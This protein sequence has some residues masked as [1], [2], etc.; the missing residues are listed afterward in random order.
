MN[1]TVALIG[2]G[3]MGVFFA[4]RL[5][6]HENFFVIADGERKTRLETKGVTVNDV[7]YKFPV[8]TPD[9]TGTIADLI[10][11]S[12]KRY[13]LEQS[14]IDIKNFVGEN[15]VILCVMNGI[16]SEDIV[17]KAYGKNRVLRSY[18]RISIVMTNGI[19]N[20][21][22]NGGQVHFG[23]DNN[24]V[25][26]DNVKKVQAIFDESGIPYITDEDMV[27]S[28]WFKFMCN[29]GEN[30][31]CAC[32][33]IPFGAFRTS[34]EANV[35]RIGAMKEVIAI[36]NKL[37]INLGQADMD[38]QN[39]DILKIP[40]FNKPSTLQDLE[41]GKKTEVDNF[42]GTVIRLGKELG[43]STPINEMFYNC[44]KVQEQKNDGEFDKE[45]Q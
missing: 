41:C 16:D 31:T 5:S 19:A 36:A 3:A 4:P 18:M 42:A 37:G 39:R 30:M 29:V 40:Y 17:A 22:P 45:I 21:N 11:I 14:I 23:E 6:E 35:V 15:T 25:L 10:I 8:K 2:L 38:R 1:N 12:V 33:G 13:S 24:T 28:Q 27:K 7:N 32:F 44:I 26:S 9:E 43:V 20:F 34:N